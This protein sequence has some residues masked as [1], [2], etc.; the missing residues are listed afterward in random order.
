[1]RWGAA[2]AGCLACLYPDDP[3]QRGDV[4]TPEGVLVP[5]KLIGINVS[6]VAGN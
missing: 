4:I 2:L 6:R 3:D 5:G 1:L